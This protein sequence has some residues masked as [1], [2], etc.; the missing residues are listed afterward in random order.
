MNISVILPRTSVFSFYSG[1]FSFLLPLPLIFY[2]NILLRFSV[3]F[4]FQIFPV[5][6]RTY[7]DC[8]LRFA[9]HSKSGADHNNEIQ[10]KKK[11]NTEK[12]SHCHFIIRHS[13]YI[14][15]SCFA[16]VF[17]SVSLSSFTFICISFLGV[18]VCQFRIRAFVFSECKAMMRF[19]YDE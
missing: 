16:D 2:I 5:M 9:I 4:L 15:Y 7:N 14:S 11:W 6:S 8:I 12:I 3:W 1:W 17:L 10:K 18:L 19:G 13:L